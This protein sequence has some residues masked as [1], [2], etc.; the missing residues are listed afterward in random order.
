MSNPLLSICIPTYNRAE[1][2]DETLNLLFSNSEFNSS[3]I[4]VI[5]SDNCSSDNTKEIVLK[6]P[7]A[8]YFYNEENIRDRN[9]AKVLS[10]ASSDYIRLFNDTLRFKHGALT[11]ILQ[12]IKQHIDKKQNLFFYNK[13]TQKA[14]CVKEVVSKSQFIKEVSYLTTW[15][16]N[17][18]CW[19]EDF[20][21]IEDKDRCWKLQFVQVDWSYRLVENGKSTL[22]YFEDLTTT[23]ELKNKGGYNVFDTFINKYLFIIKKEKFPV[24]AYEIEKY[25]LLRHFVYPWLVNMFVTNRDLFSFETKGV[26]QIIFKK[27]W[28]E[29]YLYPMILLFWLKKLK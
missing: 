28:Y 2:L 10:Y 5:I 18:G 11:K 6:Y 14:E 22:I 24:T 16:G 3:E 29:P 23:A 19:R 27:Y 4:E 1:V 26:W 25:R 9:F 12:I 21:K 15:I 7:L 13:G 8:K 17:F 20:L